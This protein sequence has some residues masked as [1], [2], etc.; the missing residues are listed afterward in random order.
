MLRLMMQSRRI[1]E[2]Q[3]LQRG[4]MEVGKGGK[5]RERE[6]SGAVCSG[7]QQQ[8][9]ASRMLARPPPLLLEVPG[10]LVTHVSIGDRREIQE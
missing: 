1:S 2:Q 4:G 5:A 6:G 7:D 8:Q 3:A 10:T 9:A